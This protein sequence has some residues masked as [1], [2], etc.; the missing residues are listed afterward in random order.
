MPSVLVFPGFESGTRCPFHNFLPSQISEHETLKSTLHFHIIIQQMQLD[1]NLVII[2]S[3]KNPQNTEEA[4]D[5]P[6]ALI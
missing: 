6:I 3:L 5:R 1:L 2:F 4:A